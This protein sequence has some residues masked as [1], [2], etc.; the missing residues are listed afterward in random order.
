MLLLLAA[1]TLASAQAPL[2]RLATVDALRQ[3][4]SYYHLQSVLLHGELVVSGA[5]VV[6]QGGEREIP[7]LLN[8]AESRSGLVQVRGQLLDVGRL[9][10]GDPRLG[11]Y[12]GA[13]DPERWP[14]PG[15]DLVLSL[16]DVTEA[17]LATSPS[18]RG[19]A[20]QPW[21]FEGQ[22]VTVI[23]QFRG[24]NLYGD[25]PSAPATSPNDFVL[26]SADAAI[27]V[28]GLRPRGRG[29]TLSVD[30]RVD[31]SQWLEVT[32]TLSQRR[33]LVTLEGREIAT[34]T[35]PDVPEPVSEP[36]APAPPPVPAEVIFS[37]PTE[38]EIDVAPTSP[39][40]VQ[41]SRGLD[42]DSLDGRVRASYL[43]APA[44]ASLELEIGYDLGTR[45]IEIR[46]AQPL[47]R[48]RTVRVELLEGLAAFDGAP[49]Q[50][51]TLTFSVGGE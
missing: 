45:A 31:T 18:I 34:A 2:R 36:D 13:R 20:L 16:A 48:F 23:G 35:A 1:A 43:G 8:G 12:D 39:V 10:P 28:T 33:G 26:R 11:L 7:V 29:F 6:L 21:R 41:F 49:V 5:R 19:L 22:E 38:G 51:W 17:Q 37:T 24:R 40:R 42:A 27:W 46:F 32:G 9:E 14:R 47:E 30:A 15:E 4:S 25:L 44:D 3:Y 50:P